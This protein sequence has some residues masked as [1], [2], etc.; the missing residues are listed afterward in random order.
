MTTTAIIQIEQFLSL[1]ATH[2]VIDVRSPSEFSQAHIPGAVSIPL[3]NDQE[4]KEVGTAYKQINKEA[5]MY[6]GLEYAGKKLTALAKEGVKAAGKKKTLLV[7]CWR[8][9]MRSKSMAWLFETMGITCYLLEGGYKSYR[10]HVLETFERPLKLIVLGGRTGSGKTDILHHLEKGGEQ[11]IDLEGLAHH[12][13]SAFG[14]LGEPPQPSTE[15][16]EN[17]LCLKL[18]EVDR[19]RRIWI[20]DESRNV[21]KCVIPGAIYNLMKE[22]RTLFLDISRE[23]RARHLVKHYAG[24]EKEELKASVMKISKRLG[25]DRTRE[26]LES[27][28]VEDF[29]ETAMITLRYYDKA[30]MFSLE[31]NHNEYEVIPTDCIEPARNAENLLNFIDATKSGF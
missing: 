26:A 4:R 9:G 2:R 30:Y 3:F 10:R 8:G 7:H 15:Q 11:V 5:A 23:L 12:K 21:G 29:F 18:E 25:G 14:A 24:F 20:E 6:I 19:E 1:S 22:S 28:D 13:G 27:V 17:E 16:F 31:K